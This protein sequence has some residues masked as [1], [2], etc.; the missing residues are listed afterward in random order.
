[1]CMQASVFIRT[2]LWP[3]RCMGS[4]W[5]LQQTKP[6]QDLEWRNWWG[7]KY[8]RKKRKERKQLSVA[9]GR[10]E[11]EGER[12]RRVKLNSRRAGVGEWVNECAVDLLCP[13]PEWSVSKL[14]SNW[15]FTAPRP[16]QLKWA[17]NTL[18]SATF[19]NYK[20]H[21]E[22]SYSGSKVGWSYVQ[23]NTSAEGKRGRQRKS[24]QGSDRFQES[25][26]WTSGDVRFISFWALTQY[27][28]SM[29]C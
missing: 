22:L 11:K 26:T 12:G 14:S 28:L 6:H 16:Y 3:G 5:P 20:D 27:F 25:E 29:K 1:M 13:A 18:S 24:K 17:N 9:G 15:W 23:E 21:V 7:E 10:R 2:H 19:S 4:C 8:R